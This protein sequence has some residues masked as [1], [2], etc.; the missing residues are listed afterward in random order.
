MTPKAWVIGLAGCCL[1]LGCSAADFERVSVADESLASDEPR[2]QAF[3]QRATY[4]GTSDATLVQPEAGVAHGAETFC[5]VKG[6]SDPRRCVLRWDLL[7]IPSNVTV[8]SASIKLGL[9][10]PSGAS[11]QAYA[12]KR[13]WSQDA[14]SWLNA[15]SGATWGKPGAA[16]GSDR[17]KAPV[18]T[19][20]GAPL[21]TVEMPL[22]TAVVQAWV[23]SPEQNHG[24]VFAAAKGVND[25]VSFASSEDA[26]A[27][28]PSVQ[29]T[30]Q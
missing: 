5:R 12:L 6:G 3:Q 4:Q 14:A 15:T 26:T 8:I 21:R 28:R 16:S 22:D 7:A 19:F 2:T 17:H 9:V 23:S 11:F 13:E 29:V 25:G 30:Y 20:L 24:I 1:S 27:W 18:A 10:D